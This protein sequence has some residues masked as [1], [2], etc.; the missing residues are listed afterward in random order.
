MT[1]YFAYGSN[2]NRRAM[3]R[4][5]PDARALGPAVLEGHRFFIGLEGWGSVAPS[6]GGIVHGVLWRLTPRDIAALHAYELVHRGLYEVRFL[7]V[8]AG[9][10]RVRAMIYLLR[11][12]GPGKPRPGYMET[13]AAAARGWNLPDCYIRSLERLSAS[14]WTGS[15]LIDAG[16][17]A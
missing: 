1:L 12:R 8:R 11:R 10:R 5:C 6:A 7:T 15:R 13:I 3:R 17:I 14:R 4:R 2:M 9:S 16:D